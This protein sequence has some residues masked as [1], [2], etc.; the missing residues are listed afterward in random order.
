MYVMCKKYVHFLNI[1][2]LA[3][4]QI[5]RF[6]ITKQTLLIGASKTFLNA[7]FLWVSAQYG[8]VSFLFW[9]SVKNHWTPSFHCA[10]SIL[11]LNTAAWLSVGK[12]ETGFWLTWYLSIPVLNCYLGL[13]NFLSCLQY[14]FVS[15]VFYALI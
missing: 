12:R 14:N 13:A 4:L 5:K 8:Q 7:H 10:W 9:P 1:L 15:C 3:S 6:W 2:L 11:P